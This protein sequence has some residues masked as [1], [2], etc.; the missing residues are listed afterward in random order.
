MGLHRATV[1]CVPTCRWGCAPPHLAPTCAGRSR[2]LAPWGS[3]SLHPRRSHS[4]RSWPRTVVRACPPRHRA[5]ASVDSARF[6]RAAVVGRAKA[7]PRAPSGPA[8]APPGQPHPCHQ[9]RGPRRGRLRRQGS[10]GPR[11]VKARAAGGPAQG[12]ALPCRGGRAAVPKPSGPWPPRRAR[13]PGWGRRSRAVPSRH[14]VPRAV[15]K[16]PHA[17][18]PT[19]VGAVPPWLDMRRPRRGRGRGRRAV[20]VQ[21]RP[22]RAAWLRAA[23]PCRRGWGWSCA[24][25]ERSRARTTVATCPRAGAH[26]RAAGAP[27]R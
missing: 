5:L 27:A 12:A 15:A 25:P 20:P 21:P 14:R 6:G 17:R 13:S 10:R 19:G 8:H 23:A 11:A 7:C 3:G 1:P 9:S 24:P 4:R 22:R 18:V 2:P 16:G 26:A